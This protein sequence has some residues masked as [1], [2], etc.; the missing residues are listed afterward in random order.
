MSKIITIA[1]VEDSMPY[2]RLLSSAITNF[3][4]E[5]GIEPIIDS[6][7]NPVDYK[8]ASKQY[9][10]VI[11]DYFFRNYTYGANGFYLS[12]FTRE[13]Y[14]ETKVIINSSYKEDEIIDVIKEFEGYVDKYSHKESNMEEPG[15]ILYILENL[16]NEG[17]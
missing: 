10:I 9:D 16:I 1:I 2:T 15:G 14:P 12:K 4:T 5:K 11:L 13:R 17:K 3:L 8:I 7:S 6:Y